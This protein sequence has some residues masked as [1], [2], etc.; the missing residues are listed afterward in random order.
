MTKTQSMNKFK[1]DPAMQ[2]K[3]TSKYAT[4]PA[5]RPSHVPATTSVGGKQVN[6]TY[7][8]A[9]GGYGYMNALGT[10]MM[11]DMM[12]DALMR[13][14]M[15]TSNGYLYQGHPNTV[16]RGGFGLVGLLLS[17]IGGV[18]IIAIIVAVAKN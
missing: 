6:I 12:S 8:Q 10:F 2:K 3:Y 13:D 15:M 11:Y 5:T 4:K 7:N 18:V 9:G 14:R 17:I 1:S 16:V